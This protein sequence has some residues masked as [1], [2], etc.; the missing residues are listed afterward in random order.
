MTQADDAGLT[1]TF[2]EGRRAHDPPCGR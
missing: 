1:P 2:E